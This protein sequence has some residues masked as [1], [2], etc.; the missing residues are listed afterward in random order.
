MREMALLIASREIDLQLFVGQVAD[1]DQALAWP[2]S[3]ARDREGRC[4]DST[5]VPDAVKRAQAELALNLVADGFQV[6]DPDDITSIRFTGAFA[7]NFDSPR[8]NGVGLP[9]A[10]MDVL[11][12]V[13]EPQASHPLVF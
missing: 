2:R 12:P 8:P 6:D 10:V 13:M 9:Q 3:L 5:F 7:V 11:A 1:A 4:L